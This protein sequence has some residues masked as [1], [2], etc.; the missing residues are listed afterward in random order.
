M[1]GIITDHIDNELPQFSADSDKIFR[2]QFLSSAGDVILK[3]RL[4]SVS[5]S[6]NK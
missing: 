4:S 1:A 3:R 5:I 2:F 6:I